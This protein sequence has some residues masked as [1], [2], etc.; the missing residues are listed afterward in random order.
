LR[1]RSKTNRSNVVTEDPTI[2]LSDSLHYHVI[3]H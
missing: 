2:I 3:Y 1:T